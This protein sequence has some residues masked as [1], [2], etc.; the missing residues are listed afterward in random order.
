MAP[1]KVS[2]KTRCGAPVAMVDVPPFVTPPK[3][4]VWGDRVFC[5]DALGEHREC[6]VYVVPPEHVKRS[7]EFTP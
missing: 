2:L 5:L 6:F 3:V 4:I 1:V 7:P